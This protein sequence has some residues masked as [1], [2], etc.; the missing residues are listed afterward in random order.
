MGNG[1]I[2]SA[3]PM[4]STALSPPLAPQSF[5]MTSYYTK[6]A[7]SLE[8]KNGY[9]GRRSFMSGRA[10]RHRRRPRQLLSSSRP[11]MTSRKTRVDHDDWAAQSCNY[12]YKFCHGEAPVLLNFLLAHQSVLAVLI[13][14]APLAFRYPGGCLVQ[15]VQSPSPTRC[16]IR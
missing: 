2:T 16:A 7:P 1:L 12:L 13:L 14:D 3:P 4:L 11:K 8:E 15:L 5:S 10:R 9:S 6:G